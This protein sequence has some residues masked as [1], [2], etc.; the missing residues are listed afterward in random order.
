MQC[1]KSCGFVWDT[2]EDLDSVVTEMKDGYL[3][4]VNFV[5]FGFHLDKNFDVMR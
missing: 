3:F 5:M 2:I 4:C 1:Y